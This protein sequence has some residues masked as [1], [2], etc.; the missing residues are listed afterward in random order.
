MKMKTEITEKK[1]H[2]LEKEIEV[3]SMEYS[4]SVF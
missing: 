1:Y 4:G 3:V 2:D